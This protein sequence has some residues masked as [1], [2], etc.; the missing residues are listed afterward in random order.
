VTSEN[1]SC[2]FNTVKLKIITFLVKYKD[3]MKIKNHLKD[4]H[5]LPLIKKVNL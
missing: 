2:L 1:E 3:N 4:L 5:R